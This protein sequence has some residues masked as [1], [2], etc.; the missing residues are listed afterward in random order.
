M[1]IFNTVIP[2]LMHFF[3][4]FTFQMASA[5]SSVK[6]DV[7][8]SEVSFYNDVRFATVYRW[9]YYCKFLMVSNQASHYFKSALER[10]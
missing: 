5:F 8:Q 4:I 1:T 7:S 9:I 10:V 3:H 2:I 6:P